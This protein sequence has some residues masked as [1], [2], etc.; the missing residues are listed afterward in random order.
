MIQRKIALINSRF[1]YLFCYNSPVYS[2]Q[3]ANTYNAIL[4]KVNAEKMTSLPREVTR[5]EMISSEYL[6]FT[7]RLSYKVSI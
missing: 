5:F 7:L 6:I 1:I 2:F 4:F 3:H